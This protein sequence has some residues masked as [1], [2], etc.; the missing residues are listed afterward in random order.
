MLGSHKKRK[1]IDVNLMVSKPY[2]YAR[3][4]Y[5]HIRFFS[6]IFVS[7]PYR[8]ARKPFSGT[9]AAIICQSFK[10]L[11]VCQEV[12]FRK[13]LISPPFCFKTLQVCQEETPEKAF[14]LYTY[15]VS[16][17]YRYAR[18]DQSRAIKTNQD[19]CFK[20]LQVCQ[21]DVGYRPTNTTST[22]FQN[23]I[24]MLGSKFFNS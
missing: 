22:R 8:Y 6:I 23:L 20:T 15:I 2:R 19:Q 24:G 12:S 11:Q 4:L 14:F 13:S 16:K 7:K 9:G 21:E 5:Q 1:N 18:K 3:K 10:T 17:P